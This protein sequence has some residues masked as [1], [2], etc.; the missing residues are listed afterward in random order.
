MTSALRLVFSPSLFLV[1]V[2][3]ASFSP[4]KNPESKTDSVSVVVGNVHRVECNQ[5]IFV[6]GSVVSP[7]APSTLSFLVSGK[8]VFVGPREGDYVKKG[9][10]IAEIDPLDYRLEVAAASLQ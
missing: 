7:D 8:V 2:L 1:L 10:K 9:Q 3:I 5:T 4:G 6:S